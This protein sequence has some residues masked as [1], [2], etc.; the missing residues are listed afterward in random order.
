MYTIIITLRTNSLICITVKI[1]DG[2]RSQ[3]KH[4]ERANQRCGKEPTKTLR[5]S[6]EHRY[7]RIYLF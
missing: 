4:S 1:Y 6:K 5:L 3:S 7:V 2:S